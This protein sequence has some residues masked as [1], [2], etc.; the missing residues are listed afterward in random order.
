MRVEG[1]YFQKTR[2]LYLGVWLVY[3]HCRSRVQ[4]QQTKGKGIRGRRDKREKQEDGRGEM[5]R[6]EGGG[7]T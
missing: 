1:D 3:T 6:G 2:L 7:R 4:W 5:K